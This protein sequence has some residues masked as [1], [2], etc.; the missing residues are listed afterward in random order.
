[1]TPSPFGFPQM[2]GMFSSSATSLIGLLELPP[3][4]VVV[5]PSVGDSKIPTILALFF[6]K[7]SM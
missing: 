5:I 2:M 6:T 1:M 3:E 7:Y 4:V